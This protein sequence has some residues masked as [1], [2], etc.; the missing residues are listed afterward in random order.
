MITLVDCPACEAPVSKSAESCPRCGHPIREKLSQGI[1]MRRS[2][3]SGAATANDS[4]ALLSMIFGIIAIPIAFVPFDWSWVATVS[5]VLAVILA[6]VAMSEIR[7]GRASGKG[8]AV[9]G[10]VT[11]ILGLMIFLLAL[12][13]LVLIAKEQ[14]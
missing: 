7:R 5:S 11:G 10:L 13:G 2:D 1:I 3:G 12:L 9:A 8:M 14:L 6:A 4:K